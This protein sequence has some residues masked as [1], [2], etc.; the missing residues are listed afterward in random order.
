[1]PD[2]PIDTYIRMDIL[3]LLPDFVGPGLVITGTVSGT[4]DG[5]K[6]YVAFL[7]LLAV[8]SGRSEN[9]TKDPAAFAKMRREAASEIH[10]KGVDAAVFRPQ[11]V[12][13]S[14]KLGM[15]YDIPLDAQ[16]VPA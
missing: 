11:A 10:V 12:A 1:M 8:V 5:Y 6:V 2:P 4:I 14:K 15:G 13:R 3:K 16:F 7:G 9:S